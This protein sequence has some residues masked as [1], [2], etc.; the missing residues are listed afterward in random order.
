MESYAT[1]YLLSNKDKKYLDLAMRVSNQSECHQRHGAVL[2]KGANVIN[3][4]CNKNK[5][6]SFAARFRKEDP[7]HA[8]VHAE[9]GA[10][11][12]IARTHTEGAT[13]YVVRINKEQYYKLSKPCTMCEAALRW[14]G[15]K[16][17]IYSTCKGFEEI[18]L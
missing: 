7:H 3:V 14:V 12:N 4:A 9:L 17:V 1:P 11:L 5:F 8:R 2:V 13:V 16:K 18:K 15:V 6:S 10:I